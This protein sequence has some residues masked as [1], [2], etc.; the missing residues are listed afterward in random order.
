[1]TIHSIV[2]GGWGESIH[3][4]VTGGFETSLAWFARM[5]EALEQTSAGS[6]T[7]IDYRYIEPGLADH[8]PLDD[9]IG[10]LEK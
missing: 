4:L 2:T 5:L 3:Y 8:T 6:Y 10:R 7:L 9:L 1:M